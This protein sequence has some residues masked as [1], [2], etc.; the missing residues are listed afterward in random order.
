MSANFD[1]IINVQFYGQFEAIGILLPWSVI[2]IFS[3]TVTFHLIKTKSNIL[4]KNF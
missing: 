2:L 1:V 4:A 3:I